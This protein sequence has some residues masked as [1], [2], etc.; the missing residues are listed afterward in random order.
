MRVII[1]PDNN[2]SDPKP[3][4]KDV[5][6]RLHR[7]N[8]WNAGERKT[9]EVKLPKNEKKPKKD[10]KKI[11]QPKKVVPSLNPEQNKARINKRKEVAQNKKKVE[12]VR[13]KLVN[14]PDLDNALKIR[15]D[16]EQGKTSSLGI[17]IDKNKDITH[18]LKR[19]G[20]IQGFRPK[21]WN[22]GYSK[23]NLP[24]GVSFKIMIGKN[25]E[26]IGQ[27]Y[28][29]I[30]EEDKRHQNIPNTSHLMNVRP[31]DKRRVAE[32]PPRNKHPQSPARINTN[33][34]IQLDKVREL[35]HQV[36]GGER[37]QTE[38][39]EETTKLQRV[40]KKY[41]HPKLEK[42][43]PVGKG[44][45]EVI[46][47]IREVDPRRGINHMSPARAKKEYGLQVGLIRNRNGIEQHV[48]HAQI[49]QKK[50]RNMEEQG[51]YQ[52]IIEHPDGTNIRHWFK[53]SEYTHEMVQRD[54]DWNYTKFMKQKIVEIVS[55]EESEL[56]GFTTGIN[57]SVIVTYKGFYGN[58]NVFM[59]RD[60]LVP[61]MIEYAISNIF[62][63]LFEGT[64]GCSIPRSNLVH[65]SLLPNNVQASLRKPDVSILVNECIDAIPIMLA[66]DD[67][68]IMSKV[69]LEDIIDSMV[70]N[71]LIGNMDYH[72][73]NLLV[74]KDGSIH[75]IDT[76]ESFLRR[77]NFRKPIV[78]SISGIIILASYLHSQGMDID[79]DEWI[80]RNIDLFQDSFKKIQG[81][82]IDAIK[83]SIIKQ[84][85]IPEDKIPDSVILQN[86]EANYNYLDVQL[87]GTK[88]QKAA[89]VESVGRTSSRPEISEFGILPKEELELEQNREEEYQPWLETPSYEPEEEEQE[90]VIAPGPALPEPTMM[91][92]LQ[93]N[94]RRQ[95]TGEDTFTSLDDYR[96]FL[97]QKLAEKSKPEDVP[98]DEGM[99]SLEAARVP[100]KERLVRFKQADLDEM[101]AR[102]EKPLPPPAEWLT[103]PHEDEGKLKR[104]PFQLG[105]GQKPG[106]KISFNERVRRNFA[107][108]MA[109]LPDQNG[110]IREE[111]PYEMV[112]PD[113][114]EDTSVSWSHSEGGPK[115]KEIRIDRRD[116]DHKFIPETGKIEYGGWKDDY[117]KIYNDSLLLEHPAKDYKNAMSDQSWSRR[118]EINGVE[119]TIKSVVKDQDEVFAIFN[120]DGSVLD[121]VTG[122]NSK[123]DNISYMQDKLEGQIATHNHPSGSAFSLPD[124]KTFIKTKAREFRVCSDKYT[125]IMRAPEDGWHIT[126]STV[127]E[128]YEKISDNIIDTVW[129]MVDSEEMDK[130]EA[131]FI[132][133]HSILTHLANRF[134]FFYKRIRNEERCYVNPNEKRVHTVYDE[135][136]EDCII[137]GENNIWKDKNIPIKKEEDDNY[138]IADSNIDKS[139]KPDNVITEEEIQNH[140][141]GI[142]RYGPGRTKNSK[143]GEDV[144]ERKT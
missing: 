3:K 143:G 71:H 45:E 9:K 67:T 44:P 75:I 51:F 43:V 111:N 94:I 99:A 48:L 81:I 127:E 13:K 136:L 27:F 123:I 40:F 1:L 98:K 112:S 2:S 37:E 121:F 87:N 74:G 102:R 57:E 62:H 14:P 107:S 49:P 110:G 105:M 104:E 21:P 4:N 128:E 41:K 52:E 144:D 10:P 95:K 20:H 130:K 66:C 60:E 5:F 101:P 70:L 88:E 126:S 108:R 36:V 142:L 19:G 113:D 124:I 133:S 77:T 61:V 46:K 30:T 134:G 8:Q 89:L 100:I 32:H 7:V 109:I 38:L 24:A 39:D 68:E 42:D 16:L 64:L 58:T 96:D 23:N 115:N 117:Q 139:M 120:E 141:D 84:C 140:D 114:I 131:N 29:P 55:T 90:G 103:R 80:P 18:A 79:T 82:G 106:E 56:T 47:F 53:D 25:G 11:E 15:D 6:S 65:P 34:E 76:A 33:I 50:A 118:V 28:K 17:K 85:Q 119:D 91:E 12:N 59:K 72:D 86:V 138:I 97:V 69:K 135:A 73:G 22:F 132:Y 122:H 31:G 92:L 137:C 129:E 63:E 35:S 83:K 116:V 93:E 78:E 54:T 125:Y 26:P